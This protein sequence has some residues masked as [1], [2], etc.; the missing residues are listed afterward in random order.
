MGPRCAGRPR[1]AENDFSDSSDK[2]SC[3]T[4]SPDYEQE[5]E[6]V[7]DDVEDHRLHGQQEIRGES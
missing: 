7:T 2:K 5:R 4:K 6:D 1:D 3:Q